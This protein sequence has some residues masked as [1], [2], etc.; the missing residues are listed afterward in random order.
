MGVSSQ[1]HDPAVL[2]AWEMTP[3]TRW[4]EVGVG[5]RA[6]LDT[7]A[8]GEIVCLCRGSNPSPVCSQTLYCMS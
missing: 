2:Y 1:R 5:L 3:R 4:I 7:Q 8:A 6:G